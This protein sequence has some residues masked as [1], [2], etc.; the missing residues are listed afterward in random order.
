MNHKQKQLEAIKASEKNEPVSEQVKQAIL[1]VLLN[2]IQAIGIDGAVTVN[3]CMKDM[4]LRVSVRDTGKGISEE[5]AEK[6]FDPFFTT[7]EKGTGLGLS[8]SY[9]IIKAHGGD[10]EVVQPKGGG[11]EFVISI[12]VNGAE[13]KDEK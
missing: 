8:I 3:T 1:N 6:L 9:Q 7:K 11:S 10:I 12:P 2:A 13:L 5:E 4:M